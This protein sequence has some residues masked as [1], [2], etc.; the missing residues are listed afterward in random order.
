LTNWKHAFWGSNYGRLSEVK[1]KYDPKMVFWVSP[2]INADFMEIKQGRLCKSP[3]PNRLKTGVVAPANG[4]T[5]VANPLTKG[6]QMFG[7]LE[8][9]VQWPGTW[10]DIEASVIYSP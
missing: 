2:G 7:E 5:N 3:T 1:D 4:N 8:K 6:D 10:K 9:W